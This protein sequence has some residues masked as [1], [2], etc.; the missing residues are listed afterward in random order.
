MPDKG[1]Y[2]DVRPA[3]GRR[4][5]GERDLVSAWANVSARP[6]GV[7]PPRGHVKRLR[8]KVQQPSAAA[9]ENGSMRDVRAPSQELSTTRRRRARLAAS[10]L[11]ALRTRHALAPAGFR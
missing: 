4:P 3:T 6:D 7:L 1:C 5:R 10:S 9:P 2:A 11:T 8:L